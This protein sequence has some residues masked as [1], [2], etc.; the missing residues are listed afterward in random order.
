MDPQ[1]FED[2]TI[3]VFNPA[4]GEI[5]ATAALPNP[6]LADHAMVVAHQ[7]WKAWRSVAPATRAHH[8]AALAQ[9]LENNRREM[10]E[11]IQQE[12]GIL[13]ARAEEE[14]S[15]GIEVLNEASRHVQ[16]CSAE[17]MSRPEGGTVTI[18]RE[19]YGVVVWIK[20]WNS[21]IA[22]LC[23]I[24]S[25]LIAGNT[26]VVKASNHAPLTAALFSR[27]ISESDIPQGVVNVLWDQDGELAQVLIKHKLLGKC[28]FTG[29]EATGRKILTTIAKNHL[30]PTFMETGGGGQQIILEDADLD[31]VFPH[32]F[33]GIFTLSGQICCAG[34]RIYVHTSLY[35]DLVERLAGSI[36]SL[37][38]GSPHSASVDLGPLISQ[39][40]VER[41]ERLVTTSHNNGAQV[42]RSESTLPQKGFFAQAALILNSDPDTEVVGEEIFGPG[43][44]VAPFRD[45]SHVLEILEHE[46]SG[47]A[48]AIYTQDIQWVHSHVSDIV[49]G[50]IWI[51]GYYQ[52]G[53]DVPF[54]GA[55][56]SGYGREKGAAG[57]QEFLQSRSVVS[58]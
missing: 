45:R 26:V 41:F 22:A 40:D 17:K 10:V 55:K 3:D 53:P 9:S 46:E 31:T 18:R 38:I 33:W 43:A 19:P 52:S 56:K 37:S 25:V 48:T 7:A 27:A 49:T 29:G 23:K 11:T 35:Q 16:I 47:L 32:I 30:R 51:N 4:S 57:V 21:P 28:A 14:V 34:N 15:H 2:G 24:G 20:S 54:G 50:T 6:Q 5:F 8:V 1:Y 12:T 39:A 58:L 42:I 44:V 13:L 36:G